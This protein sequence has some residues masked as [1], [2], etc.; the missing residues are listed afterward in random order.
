MGF[1]ATMLNI[2]YPEVHGFLE[3]KKKQ[4]SSPV[5]FLTQTLHQTNNVVFRNF[6]YLK[7]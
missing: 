2:L 3:E 4:K 7:V 1:A 6:L 5:A